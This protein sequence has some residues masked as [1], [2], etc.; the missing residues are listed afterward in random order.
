MKLFF[1]DFPL[2]NFIFDWDTVKQ[3]TLAAIKFSVDSLG[4][5]FTA[6]NFSDQPTP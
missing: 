3:D 5:Q 6:I 4:H 2:I 1:R